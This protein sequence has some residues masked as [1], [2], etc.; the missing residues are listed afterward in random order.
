MKEWEYPA[1]DGRSITVR[2]ALVD[3]AKHLHAGFRNVV[4]EQ[5]W[6]PTF[7]P[8]SHVSD[9]MNW[10]RRTKSTREVLLVAHINQEYAGHLSLQP[11]EWHASQHVAKL[12][13]IVRKECR[14]NGIGRSLMLTSEIAAAEREYS[15][16]I[17]STFDDNEAAK[18]LYKS[19]GY[20]LCGAHCGKI[21]L[22]EAYEFD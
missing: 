9:W 16:I 5:Q 10:I 13:I 20:R 17:L 19:L 11:E 8:N 1:K 12:G 22:P 21:S 2:E 7:T 18:N 14:S 6:L 4:E 3:D 15:K